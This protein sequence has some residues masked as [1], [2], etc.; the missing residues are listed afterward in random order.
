MKCNAIL[1][2]AGR[3]QRTGLDLPK[4]WSMLGGKRMAEWSVLA[5]SAS[6]HVDRIVLVVGE[7]DVAFATAAYG[8]LAT[9]VAGGSTR[10][11]S[12]R[13]GLAVLGPPFLAPVLIHDA[14]RPGL[15]EDHLD[16]LLKVLATHDGAAPALPVADTLKRKSGHDLQ[17]VDR[18]D[19]FRVQTPQVFTA[20]LVGR[21]FSAIS[22]HATDDFSVAERLGARLALVPGDHRL[23]KVT[24]AEDFDR[25]ERLLCFPHARVFRTGQG[26]DVHGFE[27]GD[28]VTLCGVKI[29]HIARLQGHSDADAGWHAVTD[30]ILGA[31]CLGDIG[32]HFPPSDPQWKGADSGVFLR[33]AQ[34]I[35]AAEGWE[36]EHVDVTLICE[37]PKIKPHRDAMRQSTADLLGLSLDAVSVKATTTEGLG[38]TGRRE[39]IAALA[40]A[41]LSRLKS[42]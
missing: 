25:M 35:A 13:S 26:F 10:A 41:T 9:V 20:A 39:G 30:A 12:V 14:A 32:D 15:V 19:L 40:S 21:V 2:A 4:Q 22:E 36:I 5:L 7:T 42:T 38:F 29:P 31:A 23:D 8:H 33:H 6:R 1:V 37:A 11:A 18:S 34:T 17:T 27:P 24:M 3:G 28:H 16:R